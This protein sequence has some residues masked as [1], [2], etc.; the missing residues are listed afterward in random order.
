[1][2]EKKSISTEVVAEETVLVGII[3]DK[4]SEQQAREY[5]DELAFL[6]ETAGIIALKRF[7]QKLPYANPKTFIGSGKIEE[8]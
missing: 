3:T 7:T 1:M 4:Q 8:V 5:L 2:I 6:A